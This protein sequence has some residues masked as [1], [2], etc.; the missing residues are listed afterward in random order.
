MNMSASKIALYAPGELGPANID[1]FSDDGFILASDWARFYDNTAGVWGGDCP[2]AVKQLIS[3]FSKEACF[4]GAFIW[5]IHSIVDT[6]KRGPTQCTRKDGSPVGMA[7]YVQ[8]IR[9]AM[10]PVAPN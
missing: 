10:E 2:P 3:R 7:D 1:R 9:E 6:Q 5:N 4:G 8:A